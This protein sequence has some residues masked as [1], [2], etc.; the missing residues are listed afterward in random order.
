MSSDN[1]KLMRSYSIE[2]DVNIFRVNIVRPIF[3]SNDSNGYANFGE[4]LF[5]RTDRET[6]RSAGRKNEYFVVP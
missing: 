2:N 3:S 6:D 4:V 5:K 1:K